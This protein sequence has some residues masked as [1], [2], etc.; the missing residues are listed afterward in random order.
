M[1][2]CFCTMCM[3]VKCVFNGPYEV[4][5]SATFIPSATITPSV[6]TM[7]PTQTSS[8]A[9][10][11]FYVLCGISFLLHLPV[12]VASCVVC[13]RWVWLTC[14]SANLPRLFLSLSFIGSVF[15]FF[16]DWPRHDFVCSVQALVNHAIAQAMVILVMALAWNKWMPESVCFSLGT[17]LHYFTFCSFLWLIFQPLV[18]A[19][20]EVQRKLYE[21]RCFILPFILMAWG[22]NNE[23][24]TTFVCVCAL[25]NGQ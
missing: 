4:P 22:N 19:M 17:L 8:V 6:T 15:L 11:I 14:M 20:G 3:Y 10:L 7:E 23:G 12:I 16:F 18:L 9:F 21:R 25:W 1:C 2:V 5:G 13:L 24:R